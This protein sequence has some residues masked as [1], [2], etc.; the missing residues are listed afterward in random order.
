MKYKVRSHRNKGEIIMTLTIY[1]KGLRKNWFIGLAPAVA[2]GFLSL[3]YI[4][5]W[6][7]IS[8][9]AQAFIELFKNPAYSTILGNEIT[10]IN[11]ATFT[12]FYSLEFFFTSNYI[13]IIIPIFLGSN[14]ISKEI[15]KKTLDIALSFPIPRWRLITEKFLVYNTYN[16]AYIIL[17]APITIIGVWLIGES[18]NYFSLIYSL[19]GLWFFFYAAGAIA[20][21]CGSIFMNSGRTYAA[22]GTIL[23][24][25]IIIDRIGGIITSLYWLQ[26]GSLF[27]YLQGSQIMITGFLPLNEVALVASFGTLCFILALIIFQ[28]REIIY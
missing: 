13:L 14:I 15:D 10:S 21:L 27:H 3:V 8:K 18:M 16:L 17:I 23:I 1:R 4:A 7:Y 11:I 22:C 25:M 20:I 5:F 26:A 28:K 2:L 12:G 6:V 24:G 9:D 19:I